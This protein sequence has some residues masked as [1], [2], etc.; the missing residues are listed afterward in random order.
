M[1][2]YPTT[3]CSKCQD[4]LVGFAIPHPIH[5][6]P[7]Q[8]E[9]C[10][11][12]NERGHSTDECTDYGVV[13][14]RGVQF[15]EQLIPYSVAKEYNIT[16]RTPITKKPQQHTY[17]HEPILEV[18]DSDKTIRAILMAHSVQPSGMMKENRRRLKQIADG[19]G[20]KLV[21]ILPK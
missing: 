8:R 10:S 1:D 15:V 11:I 9:Y 19:L 21:Y 16:S 20:R 4:V 12:C 13:Q 5:L 17:K 3:M 14:C 2:C 6:C 7:L 18:E